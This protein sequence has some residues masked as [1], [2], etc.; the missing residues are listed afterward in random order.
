MMRLS[1]NLWFAVF[2]A[3]SLYFIKLGGALPVRTVYSLALVLFT[4]VFISRKSVIKFFSENKIIGVAIVMAVAGSLATLA[5]KG[6]LTDVFNYIIKWVVQPLI[7]MCLTYQVAYCIGPRR[8]FQII[9]A[10]YSLTLV[11][12]VL[13]G[14][15]ISSAWELRYSVY[16]VQDLSKEVR[17]LDEIKFESYDGSFDD[18]S[19]A[20]GLSWSAIHLSYHCCLVIGML[21]LTRV[22][23]RYRPIRLS[24]TT[25]LA[26]V[27]L[28]FV[29]VVL[30]G[31]RSALFGV[32]LLPFLYWWWVVKNKLIFIVL[33]TVAGVGLWFV[34]PLVQEALN[35]RV[36]QADDSSASM[37]LPLYLFGL[38]LF[39]DQP[40][41]YGWLDQSIFY[42]Q[43]YW[44]HFRHMEGAE[45]IFLRGLHNYLL[46]IL[47]V[48]GVLG[49]LAIGYLF[50][51]MRVS[52]GALF[53]IALA[54]Y[55]I[56]SLFH[57]GGVFYGGNYVWVFI[58]LAKYL[59]D[60]RVW[61]RRSRESIGAQ[62]PA[63]AVP[64]FT[65]QEVV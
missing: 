53:L 43:S 21:F 31:T 60:Q 58:G 38:T 61:F 54:P 40:W 13:Q 42:A 11:V 19:R 14:L 64:R 3:L 12:G 6:D 55:L 56:N 41:G 16:S 8:T 5:G 36:L 48:Y 2:M 33:A 7:I 45:S 59:R 18:A 26:I 63:F 32:V 30:S 24:D 47:W 15:E 44:Q 28:A 37:R 51:F 9:V 20:R 23:A 29:A 57:N 4:F 10:A 25:T 50:W 65:K 35:L 34:L 62:I 22:D 27:A 17:A 52:F 39:I 1:L 46:N 49:L